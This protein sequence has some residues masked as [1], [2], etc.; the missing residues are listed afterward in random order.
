MAVLAGRKYTGAAYALPNPKPPAGM[1]RLADRVPG[2]GVHSQA[3]T[4]WPCCWRIVGT[5]AA[6]GVQSLLPAVAGCAV[7]GQGTG[8]ALRWC[9]TCPPSSMAVWTG[10]CSLWHCSRL[11][12]PAW[13]CC[14]RTGYWCRSHGTIPAPSSIAA[15]ADRHWCSRWCSSP[16]RPAQYGRRL[17]DRVP[18]QATAISQSQQHGCAAG[19]Q[20]TGVSGYAGCPTSSPPAWPC[21]WRTGYWCS[22]WCSSPGPSRLPVTLAGQALVQL[23]VALTSSPQQYGSAARQGALAGSLWYCSLPQGPS[24]AVLLWT[25]Y[26]C[27]YGGSPKPPAV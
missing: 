3:P 25:G 10:H 9:L 13:P 4:V 15:L 18:V 21:C 16:S 5:G 19:G 11:K 17:A 23:M 26:W 8:A 14:W 24:M 12:V 2:Y 22:R 1:V 7:G 6:Y 27:S 20:G